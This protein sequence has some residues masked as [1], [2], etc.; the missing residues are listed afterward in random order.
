M[1]T[2]I[3]SF[4]NWLKGKEGF[5]SLDISFDQ[6]HVHFRAEDLNKYYNGHAAVSKKFTS[7]GNVKYSF[8]IR[9][10]TVLAIFPKEDDHFEGIIRDQTSSVKGSK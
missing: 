1:Y 5:I 7:F 9:G 4:T 2:K 6:V 8:E 3:R 10:V